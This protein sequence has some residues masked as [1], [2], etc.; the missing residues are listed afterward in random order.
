[1]LYYFT[2]TMCCDDFAF[3]IIKKW[4]HHS[5]RVITI[6]MTSLRE[7]SH[8]THFYHC[9]YSITTGT[10]SVNNVWDIHFHNIYSYY[11]N[12]FVIIKWKRKIFLIAKLCFT[13]FL[14]QFDITPFR[15]ISRHFIL[16]SAHFAQD[17]FTRRFVV[18][19]DQ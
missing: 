8:V 12:I 5:C 10:I 6:V 14:Q 19:G 9:Y 2:P 17:H 13:Y 7:K 15:S 1:M 3:W 11:G 18:L 16:I 4:S